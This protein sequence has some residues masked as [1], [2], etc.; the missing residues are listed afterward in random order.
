VDVVVSYAVRE[1]GVKYSTRSMIPAIDAGD[2]VR[3]I[4]D[5]HGIGG[6]HETMAGGFVTQDRLPKGK[7]IDTF[8]RVRAIAFVERLAR[9]ST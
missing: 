4:V 7:G 8:T 1:S 5:G 6:G 9:A 3:H 2:L